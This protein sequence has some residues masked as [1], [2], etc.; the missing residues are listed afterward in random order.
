MRWNIPERLTVAEGDSRF[1]RPSSP[2]PKVDGPVDNGAQASGGDDNGAVNIW[3]TTTPRTDAPHAST[4]GRGA[5][6]PTGP[7]NPS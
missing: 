6:S 3:P 1:R 2:C 7:P 4:T 5:A